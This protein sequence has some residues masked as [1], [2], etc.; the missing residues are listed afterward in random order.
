LIVELDGG[1]HGMDDAIR[2]DAERTDWLAANG[3]RVLRFWNGD[4]LTNPE[5]VLFTIIAA[6]GLMA[7]TEKLVTNA[8]DQR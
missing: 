4:V 8:E 2:Y 5:G 3:Y 6:A 7:D 1:Q